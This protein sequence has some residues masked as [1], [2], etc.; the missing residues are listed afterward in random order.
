MSEFLLTMLDG[1]PVTA[2][3]TPAAS[4]QST[5]IAGGI[6]VSHGAAS[7]TAP[8]TLPSQER[9]SCRSALSRNATPKRLAVLDTPRG[10][11]P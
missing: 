10:L 3:A 6:D 2:G 9:W 1:A 8:A 5:G 11:G 7:V 4:W